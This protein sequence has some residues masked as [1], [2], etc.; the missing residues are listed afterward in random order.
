MSTSLPLVREPRLD[1]KPPDVTDAVAV[2]ALIAD[3][4]RAAILRM[5][6]DGSHCVCDLAASARTT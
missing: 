6:C 3:R 2:G 4:T 5:L 1:L